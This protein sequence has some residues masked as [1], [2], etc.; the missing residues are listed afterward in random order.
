MLLIK[1]NIYYVIT[2]IRCSIHFEKLQYII[3]NTFKVIT[4]SNFIVK[5]KSSTPVRVVIF[6]F[7]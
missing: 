3:V 5:L 7:Q 4:E 1:I 2:F 6:L